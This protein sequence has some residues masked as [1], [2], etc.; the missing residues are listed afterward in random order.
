MRDPNKTQAQ[1]E[2]ELAAVCQRVA[3]LE[4]PCAGLDAA[5]PLREGRPIHINRIG[6]H[7]ND[8]LSKPVSLKKLMGMIEAQLSGR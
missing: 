3:E 1:L 7:P 2:A 8:Y 5:D 6:S 4:T